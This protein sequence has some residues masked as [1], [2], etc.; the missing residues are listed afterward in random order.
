VSLRLAYCKFLLG[1]QVLL[2]WL[3]ETEDRTGSH[4]RARPAKQNQLTP[5]LTPGFYTQP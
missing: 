1:M 2:G 5:E 3:E 4:T